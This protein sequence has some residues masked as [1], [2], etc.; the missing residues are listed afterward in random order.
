MERLEKMIEIKEI[1]TSEVPSRIREFMSMEQILSRLDSAIK[2]EE[3]SKTITFE[4]DPEMSRTL[5]LINIGQYRKYRNALI[6]EGGNS[7]P[8]DERMINAT[9]HLNSIPIYS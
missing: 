4:D 1:I 5:H 7:V 6:S 3:T 8:Y 9:L 2:Q